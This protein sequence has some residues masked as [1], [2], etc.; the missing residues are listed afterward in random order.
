MHIQ[1]PFAAAAMLLTWSVAFCAPVE[2]DAPEY[3]L[4]V[5]RPFDSWSGDL[6]VMAG[7]RETITDRRGRISFRDVDANGS[8]RGAGITLLNGPT[9][10]PVTQETVALMKQRGVAISSRG[11]YH[12]A[13]GLPTE[14]E[15]VDYPHLRQAQT[16]LYEALIRKQGDPD[17][18]PGSMQAR[19]LLGNVMAIA[20]VGAGFDKFGGIGASVVATTFAG[21]IAHLPL[22]VRQSFAPFDLPELDPSQFS[23]LEVYPVK[24]N[25]GGSPGQVIV[26]YKGEPS[27]AAR[28]A[29][30]VQALASVAGSDTTPD[31]IDAARA[32][33][34]QRRREVWTACVH[35][36]DCGSATHDS[37]ASK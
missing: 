34:L 6:S 4:I 32:A 22:G 17:K 28:H 18:V 20:A 36:G 3:H 14:L 25:E 16:A 31:A 15:P 11:S 21:D 5:C 19:R 26:A 35:A 24:V 29:A 23:K 30:L 27:T 33:D 7:E 13:M 8:G 2:Y 9:D 1:T 12:W 37:E 10:D